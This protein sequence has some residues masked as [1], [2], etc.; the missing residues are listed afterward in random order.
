MGD[1][2]A[3]FVK[4]VFLLHEAHF[5]AVVVV[6]QGAAAHLAVE[7]DGVDGAVEVVEEG[8]VGVA[9][10]TLDS[11]AREHLGGVGDEGVD[12]VAVDVGDHHLVG[13]QGEVECGVAH[14]GDAVGGAGVVLCQAEGIANG[15]QGVEH[16][17]TAVGVEHLGVV[18][19]AG[20]RNDADAGGV[21][22]EEGLG[23][24]DVLRLVV[25]AKGAGA[26]DEEGEAVGV[27]VFFNVGDFHVTFGAYVVAGAV[28]DVVEQEGAV[29]DAL[30]QCVVDVGVVGA[31][32]TGLLYVRVGIVAVDVELG[33]ES[34]D[35]AGCF[36]G[37]A[38]EDGVARKGGVGI[39]CQELRASDY[40]IQLWLG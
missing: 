16:V 32:G 36:F 35:G 38:G 6:G 22:E 13:G 5:G 1:S 10:L 40:P 30:A 12:R 34:L 2:L 15:V 27:G 17:E 21:G 25:A 29:V 28:A 19:G 24:T 11:D 18:D 20:G 14:K 26:G 9:Y 33:V 39:V 23:T 3:S 8:T 4:D 31:V 37:V 7:D